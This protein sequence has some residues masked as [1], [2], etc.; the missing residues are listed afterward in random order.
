MDGLTAGS[1]TTPIRP[2]APADRIVALDV[3]RGFAL[4]GILVMNIQSFSMI[5]AAYLNPTAFGSLEGAEGGVWLL[6]QLFADGKFISIFSMLFGAGMVLMSDRAVARGDAP[7]RLHYRRMAGLLVIGLA[8]S[9]L[10][11][12][13]DILVPYAVCGSLAFLLVRLSPKGLAAAGLASWLI[14][15]M[16]L[17]LLGLAMLAAPPAMLAELDASDWQVSPQTIAA[18]LKTFRGG[19][20]QQQEQRVIDSLF[21]QLVALPLMFWQLTGLMLIGMAL[22]KT[23][24][25]VGRLSVRWYANA[26]IFALAVGLPATAA[27]V[28][29]NVSH[30]W[31][32][33]YSMLLGRLPNY[34]GSLAVAIAYMALLIL[35]LRSPLGP[36]LTQILAPVGKL[37]LTNYLGQT[38]ICTTIFYGHG[39][40]WY[41]HLDR[42]EQLV[43]VVGV[44]LVQIVWSSWWLKRHPLGPAEYLWRRLTYGQSR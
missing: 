3:L 11:W 19:W 22:F 38:L 31:N 18:D 4:L 34:F 10:L 26:A 24:F 1:L 17:L 30:Q 7:A 20:L 36:P 9:Y 15:G 35:A 43:V 2:T 21:M 8:H 23:G 29:W 27:G 42:V 5:D 13:G 32:M 14:G 6:S 12:S 39:L 37:A 44:W 33:E 16:I 28:Y 25:L 40:G 41:G